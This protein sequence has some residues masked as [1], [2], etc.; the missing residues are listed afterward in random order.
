MTRWF[1]RAKGYC[2]MTCPTRRANSAAQRSG[3]AVVKCRPDFGST[4]ANTFAVPQRSY[5]L[6][7]LAG[8]PGLAAIGAHVGV[9]RHRFLVQANDRLGRIVGL[10]IDG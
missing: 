9:Q 6:S 2:S 10:L 5:S 1:F 8:L 4:T 7:C 3:V